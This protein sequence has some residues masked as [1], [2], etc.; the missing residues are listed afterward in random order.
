MRALIKPALAMTQA[1]KIAY[2]QSVVTN[3]IRWQS[4]TTLWRRHD[5]WASAA[6]TL[7]AGA[8]DAEDRAIVKLQ[9]L[10]ALGFSADDLFLTMA[11]DSIGGPITVLSVRQ[12]N[13]FLILPDNGNAFPAASRKVEFVP[14][15]SLGM[16]GAWLHL[17]QAPRPAIVAL[18]AAATSIHK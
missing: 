9:A 1:Q 13:H 18:K 16:R 17:K 10:R 6:E 11:R 5:Y 2:I 4:D 14:L 12:G 7:N 15:I 8:G 3:N